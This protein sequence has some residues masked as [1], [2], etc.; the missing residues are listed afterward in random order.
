MKFLGQCTF[1]AGVAV[2]VVGM[3]SAASAQKIHRYGGVGSETSG[4]SVSGAA[5]AAPA[6]T[7]SAQSSAQTTATPSTAAQA[8]GKAGETQIGPSHRI[9]LS[10]GVATSSGTARETLD[11]AIDELYRGII[12]GMR[13]QVAHLSDA[14]EKGANSAHSNELTWIGFRPTDGY[15]RVF[16]QTARKANYNIRRKQNPAVIEVIIN[17]TEIPARNFTRFIDTSF[18]GRNVKRVEANEIDASTVQIT[19]ELGTFEQPTVRESGNYIY[20]DFPYANPAADKADSA[21]ADAKTAQSAP[22]A[23]Q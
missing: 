21:N 8:E 20:L 6:R 14:R 10:S 5:Q 22:S 12:P 1:V 18:F 23:F 7:A 16:F 4:A 2:I 19:I 11:L 9:R 17:N 3:A 15:T 13:D